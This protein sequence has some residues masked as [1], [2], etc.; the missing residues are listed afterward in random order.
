M[1]ANSFFGFS[2]IYVIFDDGTDLYWARSRVLEYM[3]G[4][5]G[6]LPAGVAPQLGPDATGVGW[7]LEYVLIDRT[8]RHNLAELRTL[9][10]WHV[11][12]Q[13]RAVPG[14]AEVAAVAAY[15]KQYQVTIDPDK[16]LAYDIPINRVVGRIRMSNQEVGG[17]VIEFTGRVHGARAG[18]HQGGPTTSRRSAW[19]PR[20]T[21]R[22]SGSATW[23][24][25]SSAPTS[26]AA[27]WTTTAWATPPEAS[28]WF[29]SA[30]ASTTC[31]S[32]SSRRSARRSSPRSPRGWS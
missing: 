13:L 22:R 18:L 25:C 5:A 29:A 1:R 24:T 4:M 11:Q 19:G 16:L 30:R 23:A 14:V 27:W 10:D 8:G 7:G 2:L 3:S 12:Y 32:G 9:Q 15:V 20:R 31:S 21:G 17:R 26:A 6:K 28:S